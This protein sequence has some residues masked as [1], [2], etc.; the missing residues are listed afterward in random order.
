MSRHS[1]TDSLRSVGS[2]REMLRARPAR[3]RAAPSVSGSRGGLE[4][5]VAR[6]DLPGVGK[7]LSYLIRAP[8]QRSYALDVRGTEIL[9]LCNG[10]RTVEDLIDKFAQAHGLTFHES[11]IAV[12]SYL[13]EMASR[14]IIALVQPK[15]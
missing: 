3:N 8:R 14:G 4:V 2:W 10:H 5:S 11:R 6:K 7:P 9:E 13:A 1:P 15:H 12:T